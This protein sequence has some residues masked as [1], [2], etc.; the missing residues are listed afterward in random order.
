M[1]RR[2]FLLKLNFL[3][4]LS[5]LSMLAGPAWSS[6]GKKKAVGII[7]GFNIDFANIDFSQPL[8][9]IARE[10]GILFGASQNIFAFDWNPEYA[11]LF[12][13]QCAIWVPEGQF[14]WRFVHPER[15]IYD[16][17]ITDR[18]SK[19]AQYNNLLLKGHALVYHG[20][21]PM[22]VRTEVKTSGNASKLLE[23]H[24]RTIVTRYKDKM[25]A[26]DVINEPIYPP[27]GRQDGLRNTLWLRH[28][29]PEY[30]D[31]AL[32]TAYKADPNALLTININNCYY[33]T[34]EHEL[35]R[36]SF[37][38]LLDRIITRNLPLHAIGIQAHLNSNQ[39][40]YFNRQIFRTFLNDISKRGYKIHITELDVSDQGLPANKSLR[41]QKVADIYEDFLS[42]TLDELS[43][44]TIITWGL[45]DKYTYMEKAKPR[46]D[47]QP[48]RPLLFDRALLKKPA[49]YAVARVLANASSR[50]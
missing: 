32:W 47:K 13:E 26:W 1:N 10:R 43:V 17:T 18:I 49:W 29:G 6:Q 7:S 44:N 9:E 39:H 38:M 46:L 48:V 25:Y 8:Q 37:L 30:I 15:G 31:L 35:K 50:N 16:F 3:A 2:Q 27:H 28:L 36:T 40:K 4:G 19:F 5:M 34:P 14:N 23:E 20:K 41:D 21:L 24:I 45:S 33:D 11:K 42:T 12:I 22:W